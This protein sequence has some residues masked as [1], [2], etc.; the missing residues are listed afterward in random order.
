[1]TASTA[2]ARSNLEPRTTDVWAWSP[3]LRDFVAVPARRTRADEYEV[4]RPRRGSAPTTLE[5]GDV[6]RCELS[7]GELVVR[8]RIFSA[9]LV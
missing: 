7:D 8:E 3:V 4:L 1:M 6:V 2:P 5:V 9:R